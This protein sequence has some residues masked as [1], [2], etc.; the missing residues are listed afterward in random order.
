MVAGPSSRSSLAERAQPDRA[1]DVAAKAAIIKGVLLVGWAVGGAIFGRIGDRLGR[2]RTL[3]LTILTYAIFTGL[4]FFATTWWHLL[5]F[6]FIAALGIGGEWAAGSAAG[7]RDA[8]PASTASGRPRPCNPAT[9]SAAF[10]PCF[11]GKFLVEHWNPSGSSSSASPPRCVDALDPAGAVP[12]PE[13]VGHGTPRPRTRRRSRALFRPG[14]ARTT[15]LVSAL[16]CDRAH[17]R[18]GLP[19]LRPQAAKRHPRGRD[20]DRSQAAR[21][22]SCGSR[23]STFSSTSAATSAAHLHRLHAIGYR[24]P[25]H[26]LIGVL[27][28][29]LHRL[30][31]PART[32]QRLHR[33]RLSAF[34]ILGLFGLF[35]PLHPAPVPDA[36]PH[37][38]A[39]H[40]LQHR[41]RRS[42]ALGAFVGGWITVHAGGAA[43][44]SGGP[45]SCT[46]PACC[47]PFIPEVPEHKAG[48]CSTCGV[49]ASTIAQ[50]DV[51]KC[52]ERHPHSS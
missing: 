43:Q 9:W 38:R 25:S 51:P 49:R 10:S 13:A 44:P 50:S 33:L 3:T 21:P 23:S 1:D 37:P 7:Q 17:H 26:L 45:A 30:R 41:P 5:I 8:P 42:P 32:Y 20:L 46:S 22:S 6:R 39:R 36:R 29:F 48:A 24:R 12:E 27:V 11:T 47:R 35:P 4:S 2:S 16:T 28:S 52:G 40:H 19:L 34:F 31:H 14:L 15:L 18:L